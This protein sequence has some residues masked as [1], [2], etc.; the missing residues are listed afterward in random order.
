VVYSICMIKNEVS[1]ALCVLCS[2]LE[3]NFLRSQLYY[4]NFKKSFTHLPKESL[5]WATGRP[6]NIYCEGL[7]CD[8]KT[9]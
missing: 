1:E 8:F 4:L 5:G 2:N 3:R 6:H 9:L 7:V